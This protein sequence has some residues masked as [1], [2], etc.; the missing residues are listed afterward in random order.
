MKAI[1]K[2]YP[3]HGLSIEEMPIPEL[4]TN[5]ILIKVQK[6]AICG[7]DVHIY[8]WDKWAQNRNIPADGGSCGSCYLEI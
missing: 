3:K 6:T 5:D 4:G 2:K 1:V 7:T 8:Q